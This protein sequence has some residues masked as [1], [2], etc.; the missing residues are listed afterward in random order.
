MDLFT[1]IRHANPTK[2][3]IGKRLIEVGQVLLLD[4][5]EG[6]V[7]PL[8]SGNEQGGQ[9]DNV[10]VARPHD[11]N[12]EGDVQAAVVDKPKRIRKKKKAASG[13]SGSNLP[14][15]K[16]KVYHG[17]SGDG[18]D[19]ATH[20][21]CLIVKVW[22]QSEH[23]LRE[24][25]KYERKC[26]RQTDLLKEKDA[27]VASLKALLSLKESL[28]EHSTLA[29]E[30]GVTATVT[31]PFVTYYVTLTPE[32]EGG[33]HT[34]S[35][36]R[37]N[38]WTHHPAERFL[39]SSDPSRHSSTNVV[40]VE[41]TFI[42][43]S[44][45]LPPLFHFSKSAEPDPAGPSNPRGTKLSA[46]TFYISEEMDSKTLQLIYVRIWNVINDYALDDPETCLIVKV[47]LQSEHNLR[48]RKKYKRKCAR[49]T[50]LLKEKDAEIASLK[51]L[52]S[53]KEVEAAKAIHLRSQV[54]V[55]EAAKAA[56]INELNNLKERN[57]ALEGVKSTLEGQVIRL[58]F[59]ASSKDTE[60]ASVNALVAKLNHDLSGLQ[61]SCDEMSIKAA[62][63]ES[64]KDNLTD[65]VSVLETTCS[66]LQLDYELMGM[67][68]HLDGEFYP[69]FLT[70]IVEYVVAFGSV[71]G[72]AIDKG[73]QTGLVAG[74]DHEKAGR[75]LAEF[76]SQK[77]ANIAC[78]M[79]SL[80]L[81]GPSAETLENLR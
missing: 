59:A 56:R 25:K 70:T 66:K 64:Q 27:E 11:L 32:H 8:A 33:G 23:N 22:L 39:I 46:D 45:I 21:T 72:L 78:I 74:I 80:R 47:W 55:V 10:E 3:W 28:L 30:V 63:L 38:L 20:Q 71:I 18:D 49:Q 69:R 5:T 40:D 17:T 79:D 58:T 76:E 62:S 48:E 12:K 67:A 31:V 50:D 75:G 36:F 81:K 13:A 6:C 51:A 7:I 1:F 29:V 9:N 24:R 65:H 53:L 37:P 52:L 43:R 77:D 34:D 73:M 60:L 35:V 2:V 44:S 61:L 16:L 41:V 19:V 14:P 15:K 57:L 26:A 4:P 68:A 54:S 42:V